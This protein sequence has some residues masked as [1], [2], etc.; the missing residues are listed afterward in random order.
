V[1]DPPAS[2]MPRLLVWLL[3][4]LRIPPITSG[5]TDPA[6][7]IAAPPARVNGKV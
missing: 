7:R 1:P 4:M 6:G 3:M 5:L 2:M